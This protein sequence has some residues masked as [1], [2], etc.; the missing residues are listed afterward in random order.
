MIKFGLLSI[1]LA[2]TF[3]LWGLAAVV[4]AQEEIEV[5][6]PYTGFENPFSWDDAQ[7]HEAGNTVFQ[8]SCAVCH[9][10]TETGPAL[11][12][13]FTA[14]D[15][16]QRLEERADFYFWTLSEGR[17]DKGM[18]GYKTILSEEERWQ[19]LTY[20]WS[21]HAE[22][23]PSE[24]PPPTVTVTE[25]PEP[26]N[27]MSCHFAPEPIPGI[28]RPKPLIGHDKLGPGNEACRACH[29]NLSLITMIEST[30]SLHL[31]GGTQ[32]PL[33]ESPQLCAQ[34][35]EKRF[36]AWDEGTHGVPLWQETGLVIPT[37]DKVK[38]TECH[39]PHQPQIV[40]LGITKPHPPEAPSPPQPPADMLIVLGG[41]LLFLAVVGVMVR[42]GK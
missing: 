1:V 29:F 40:L 24:T 41:S 13:D 38:C 39:D 34:C 6:A 20:I 23:T 28:P 21:I 33:S 36:D 32:F 37:T 16:P 22:A 7:T 18:P 9:V 30:T 3:I 15:F 19:A 8:K 2:V 14:A 25:E 27:C 26:L 31:A 42:K 11:G 10:A 4:L 35:H 17:L 5:P 12:P